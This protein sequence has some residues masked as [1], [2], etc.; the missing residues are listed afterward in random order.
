MRPPPEPGRDF[1]NRTRRQTLANPR[2]N[3]AGPLCSG[4][5][6]RLRPFLA[7][8]LPI[9]FHLLGMVRTIRGTDVFTQT[10]RRFCACPRRS[11]SLNDDRRIIDDQPSEGELKWHSQ[12]VTLRTI[13]DRVSGPST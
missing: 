10:V 7:R 9:V 1:Q 8:L 6:P 2:K 4:T 13:S 12:V 3:C 11:L 5:A